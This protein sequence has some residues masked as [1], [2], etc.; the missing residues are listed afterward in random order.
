MA[1]RRQRFLAQSEGMAGRCEGRRQEACRA[2]VWEQLLENGTAVGCGRPKDTAS[3]IIMVDIVKC[4]ERRTVAASLV[5]GDTEGASHAVWDL[6]DVAWNVTFNTSTDVSPTFLKH[7]YRVYTG[8][9]ERLEQLPAGG[10]GGGPDPAPL[11]ALLL[12]LL[13]DLAS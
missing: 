5:L 4:F 6:S 2:P 12:L 11:L 10:G 13:F 8:A 7:L 9:V 3:L 1:T